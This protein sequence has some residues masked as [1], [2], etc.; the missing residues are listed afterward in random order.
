MASLYQSVI[1]SSGH[2]TETPVALEMI[3][4]N[5]IIIRINLTDQWLLKQGNLG[6][7]KGEVKV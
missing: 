5:G 3:W 4:T 6:E 7:S 1:K 2:L